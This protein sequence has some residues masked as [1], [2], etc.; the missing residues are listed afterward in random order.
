MFTEIQKKSEISYN[1][2]HHDQERTINL[3]HNDEKIQ[4]NRLTG[5]EI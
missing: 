1:N 2:Y 5:E 3:Q 4:V